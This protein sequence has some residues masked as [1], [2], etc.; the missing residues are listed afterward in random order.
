MAPRRGLPKGRPPTAPEDAK[1]TGEE[2]GIAAGLD[3][4]NQEIANAITELINEGDLSKHNHRISVWVT[5]AVGISGIA[6]L[7]ALV[8]HYILPDMFLTSAQAADLQKFLFGGGA[9]AI[10]Q[11]KYSKKAKKS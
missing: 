8:V 10:F 2:T 7:A 4:S 6:M 11:S 3:I 1:S 5:Y 9:G